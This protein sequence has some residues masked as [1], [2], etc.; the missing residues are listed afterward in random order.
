MAQIIHLFECGR[1]KW[2]ISSFHLQTKKSVYAPLEVERKWQTGQKREKEKRRK[3]T[4]KRNVEATQ[5]KTL[6][7]AARKTNQR[8]KV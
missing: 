1:Q 8:A 6:P 7:N 2:Y 5:V 4:R 3:L